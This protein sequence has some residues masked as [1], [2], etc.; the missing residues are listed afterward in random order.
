[1]LIIA[2]IQSIANNINRL[3]GK[4][5][6]TDGTNDMPAGDDPARGIV[7]RLV[8]RN[9]TELELCS[10]SGAVQTIQSASIIEPFESITGFTGS[11]GVS[12][13]ALSANH[14]GL[15]QY[16]VSFDKSGT[17]SPVAYIQKTIPSTNLSSCAFEGCINWW[18]MIP[19]GILSNINFIYFAIG[20]DIS[21]LWY[22]PVY[23]TNL[24]EGWNHIIL[25]IDSRSTMGTGAVLTD[26]TYI[27][28]YVQTTSPGVTFT[29]LLVDNCI[30]VRQFANQIIDAYNLG[31]T[32]KSL[33]TDSTTDII[34]PTSGADVQGASPQT[35]LPAAGAGKFNRIHSMTISCSVNGLITV[36]NGI[37]RFYT[38]A[39]R[40]VNVQWPNGK[41]Q[42]TA[43][44]A[45]T[46]TNSAGGSVAA[47]CTYNT[48]A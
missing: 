8:D 22:W 10:S 6:V 21:N 12:N 36:S 4:V 26:I 14:M 7:T 33:I 37:G 13:I 39:N 9:Q 35:L 3:L 38:A 24:V 23:Q 40:F 45:I 48:E 17:T 15:G 27:N 46:V 28:T 44:T 5:K 32:N 11:A 30:F 25:S 31:Y 29:G 18:V 41:K 16:S 43:N 47:E 34:F 19:S 1:M 2:Q 42:S 20:S